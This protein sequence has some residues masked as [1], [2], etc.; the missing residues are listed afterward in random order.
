MRASVT[1][2]VLGALGALAGGWLVARWC[3]GLVLIGESGAAVWWGVFGHDDGRPA[4][5]PV[6]GQA[7]ALV[8]VL[9]RFRAS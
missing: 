3:L 8:Q 5:H 7:T 2:C 1:A 6:P 9:E 4:L